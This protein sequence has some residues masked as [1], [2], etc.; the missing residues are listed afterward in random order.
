MAYSFGEIC[1]ITRF[2]MDQDSP[3]KRKMAEVRERYNGDWVLPYADVEGAP[4]LPPL[5]PA[6]IADAVDNIALQCGSIQ[7]F[8]HCP[9]IDPG[10]DLGVRSRAYADVRRK[11]LQA[12]W[13][14][15]NTRLL[16][17][18]AYRHLAGYAT[19]S[20]V[21][22]PDFE[23]EIPAIRLRDPL[24][25]YVEPKDPEDLTPP[26]YGAW[27]H[28][29]SGKWIAANYPECREV[30]GGR[31]LSEMW[32]MVEWIDADHIVIGL[33]GP[34]HPS[35]ADRHAH[36]NRLAGMRKEVRRWPNLAGMVTATSPNRVTLDRVASQVANIV[37]ITDLMARLMALDIIATEKSIFPDT[38]IIG[39]AGQAP[40][41]V[42]GRWKDGRDGEV[43]IVLDADQV[44]QLR[45][46]PD[47]NNKQTMDRLERNARVSTSNVPQF[48]GETYGALRTGRGIDA[49]GGMAVDPK[50]QE[51]QEIMEVAAARMNEAVFATYEGYWGPK[52]FSLYTGGSGAGGVVEFTPDV[53]V[54][55]RHNS[56]H[57]PVPGSDV[58]S[59][60]IALGQL[61]GTKAISIATF[62][63][64][65]PWIDDP[66]SEGRLR[67]E[68]DIEE[69]VMLGFLEQVRG[70]TIPLI[71]AVNVES[72]VKAGHDIIEAI[73]RADE[74]AR[75]RQA[76]APA[77]QEETVDA[78][79]QI[80]PPE[81]Q[82]GLA[83][84]GSG[85]EAGLGPGGQPLPPDIP[86][87]QPS[88]GNFRKLL[89]TLQAGGR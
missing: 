39:K 59:T 13:F 16:F 41:L 35:H 84:P 40:Q 64:L 6:L 79:S 7:P 82:P 34:R 57:Y 4:Q 62:R 23:R 55:T 67:T 17:R 46:T 3:L 74:D 9:P 11:A 81:G 28:G 49:L 20:I 54:E 72:Y 83:L 43:N 14:Q 29:K 44:G 61:L 27:I 18:R 47:P 80:L 69:A 63:A 85:A 5:T 53:H 31:D 87:P 75:A 30:V 65:H 77:P 48:G 2:L 76:T 86:P 25:S 66:D 60:T 50:V 56:V 51:L 88:Q 1:E 10:K 22:M 26:N 8:I 19:T 32:D 15:N 42:G 38:Y 73:M 70:G 36:P 52:Q 12:T 89:Q 33:L 21:V 37:G 78:N 68:E 71:D 45:G 58:Q 24:S